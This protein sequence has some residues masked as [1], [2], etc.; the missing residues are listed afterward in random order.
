MANKQEL[1]DIV[2]QMIDI[3]G[4]RLTTGIRTR[5][6]FDDII[7]ALFNQFGQIYTTQV[8]LVANTDFVIVV[9]AS[10]YQ[11]SIR[12]FN[13]WDANGNEIGNKLAVRKGVLLGDQTLTLNSA[14]SGVFVEV[15]ITMR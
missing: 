10:A 5:N 4:Q 15:N 9:P 8:N 13:V 11:G 6:V 7:D 12:N 3:T 2:E 14:K 1:K